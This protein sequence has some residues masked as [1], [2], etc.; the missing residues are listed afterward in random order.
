[1]AFDKAE[2]QYQ[3]SRKKL[4][5]DAMYETMSKFSSNAQSRDDDDDSEGSIL[6][7]NIES[8]KPTLTIGK[9]PKCT[10]RANFKEE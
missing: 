8:K 10:R 1:M 2:L 4:A 9:Q 5:E 3:E 7:N 6:S